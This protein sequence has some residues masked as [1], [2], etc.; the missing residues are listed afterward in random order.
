MKK[1]NLFRLKRERKENGNHLD[2]FKSSLLRYMPQDN[3]WHFFCSLDNSDT[4][5]FKHITQVS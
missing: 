3:I 1:Q 5:L 2:N 4:A